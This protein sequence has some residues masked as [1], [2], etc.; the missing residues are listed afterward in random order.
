VKCREGVHR[1][2]AYSQC[3]GRIQRMSGTKTKSLTSAIDGCN[4]SAAQPGR[5]AGDRPSPVRTAQNAV[6]TSKTGLGALQNKTKHCR[7]SGVEP[8]FN[9]CVARSLV[10]VPTELSRF[11]FNAV[12]FAV[13]LTTLFPSSAENGNGTTP[14]LPHTPWTA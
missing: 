13:R 10:T 7:P 9:S 3:I 6:W 2:G 1:V 14:L 11:L 12:Q 5:H 8:Q 4:Q